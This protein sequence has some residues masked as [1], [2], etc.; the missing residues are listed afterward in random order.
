MKLLQPIYLKPCISYMIM[1]M[2]LVAVQSVLF[3][4][5]GRLVDS[6]S[7]TSITKSD[8]LSDFS[9]VI[10]ID[11]IHDSVVADDCRYCYSCHIFLNVD[12]PCNILQ[13]ID[14]SPAFSFVSSELKRYMSVPFRPPKYA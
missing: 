3:S 2:I 12:S 4:F 1:I 9:E 6:Y 13:T 10:D 7:K 5:E 11:L 14:Y 8:S